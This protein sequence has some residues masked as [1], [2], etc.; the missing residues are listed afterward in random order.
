[1]NKLILVTGGT[2]F[3]GRSLIEELSKN[4]YD[5]II[6]TR[7]KS[8]YANDTRYLYY[9]GTY[10]S[11]ILSL[12]GKKIQ[13]IIHLATLFVPNH[14]S[15]QINELVS[16][17]ILLGTHLLELTKE[18]E[19]SYFIN[20]STYAISV[21]GLNY[22]PQNLYSATK[23]AFLDI[24]KYF[25]LICCKTKFV[26]LELFDTYG[27]CDKR[28][29]FINLLIKS[30]KENNDFNM[31]LGEQEI[32]YQYI[33]DVCNAFLVLIN[34]LFFDKEPT[35]SNYSIFNNEVYKLG[36]LADLV[37]SHTGNKIKINKGFYPY[38]EREI[39]KITPAFNKISNWTPKI[40]LLEG[41]N[42]LIKDE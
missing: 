7:D 19:I 27:T 23:K 37:N 33:D 3:I 8:I 39:M 29:K 11:L 35:E 21:N 36:D 6:L 30:I 1:M 40:S 38:R 31:S 13:M 18:L 9:D 14:K 34:N 17:N 10:D 2:G 32:S 5:L 41:V 24:I 42:K 26:N 28:P 20:T 25:E 4:N 15:S 22:D 16:S 12:S